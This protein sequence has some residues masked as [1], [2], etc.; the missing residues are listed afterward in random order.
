MMAMVALTVFVLAGCGGNGA[1]STAPEDQVPPAAV[2]GVEAHGVN[3][4]TPTVMLSWAAGAE[5]DLA[6]YRIYRSTAGAA[7]VLVGTATSE[8]WRDATMVPGLEQV[9]QVSAVDLSANESA[10][11]SSGTVVVLGSGKDEHD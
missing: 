8:F 7:A 4:P 5:A 6:G 1:S 10:R 11:T 2:V 3:G 9:Y